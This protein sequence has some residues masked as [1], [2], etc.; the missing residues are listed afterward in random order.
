MSTSVRAHPATFFLLDWGSQGPQLSTS[1]LWTWP[2][3]HSLGVHCSGHRAASFI[4][5]SASLHQQKLDLMD[6][7]PGDGE[8]RRGQARVSVRCAWWH[9]KKY[10][11]YLAVSG[12]S[13][14][15]WASMVACEIFS[16]VVTC[17]LF[18]VACRIGFPDQ[19]SNLGPCIGSE[20]S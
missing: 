10:F 6:S 13:C 7:R 8:L 2:W 9:L 15:T 20:E 16:C 1:L 19:G 3:E 14:G 18:V 12:L 17:K 4:T 11:I 5:P